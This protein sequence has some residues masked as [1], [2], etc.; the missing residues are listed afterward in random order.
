MFF[1]IWFIVTA[2]IL[3]A[4]IAVPWKEEEPNDEVRR[5]ADNFNC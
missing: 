2:S 5:E 1:E 4:W 3:M